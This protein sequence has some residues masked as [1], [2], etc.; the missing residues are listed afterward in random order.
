MC[1]RKRV[2]EMKMEKQTTNYAQEY[3]GRIKFTHRSHS[4]ISKCQNIECL[5]S[6]PITNSTITMFMKSD[7]GNEKKLC[8]MR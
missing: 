8:E 6:Y 2:K 5:S 4:P 7:E 1:V 3:V